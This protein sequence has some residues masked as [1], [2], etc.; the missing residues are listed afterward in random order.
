MK[1]IDLTW[2]STHTLPLAEVA[3]YDLGF[4]GSELTL[5]EPY[6]GKEADVES[7]GMLFY[8]IT[9]G[10]HHFRASTKKEMDK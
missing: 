7:L 2:P 6:D 5:G 9:T 3:A 8:F 4:Y 1:L 10:S